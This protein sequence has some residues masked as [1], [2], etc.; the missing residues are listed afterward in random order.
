MKKKITFI[1][2][3]MICTAYSQSNYK[4]SGYYIEVGSVISETDSIINY[5]FFYTVLIPKSTLKS[6][7]INR[8]LKFKTKAKLL[9]YLKRKGEIFNIIS[10]IYSKDELIKHYDSLETKVL[11]KNLIN[12]NC[13]NY[14]P[15]KRKNYIS[16]E[17]INFDGIKKDFTFSHMKELNPSF[18]S[19][20]MHSP[21]K[22][23]H[24]IFIGNPK[25]GEVTSKTIDKLYFINVS[26]YRNTHNKYD[27]FMIYNCEKHKLF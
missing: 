9:K 6:S 5:D 8:I 7:Q 11:S 17:S 15:Q 20:T 23:K 16:I 10:G 21:L 24:E 14:F 19:N 27:V 1:L 13:L 22:L 12:I 26:Y 2:F 3:W 25:T 18:D 4:Y